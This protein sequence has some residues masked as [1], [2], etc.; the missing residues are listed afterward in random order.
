M[1]FKIYAVVYVLLLLGFLFVLG[2]LAIREYLRE[3]KHFQDTGEALER[4]ETR[5]GVS[6]KFVNVADAIMV[7]VILLF[8]GA[9]VW[10]QRETEVVENAL[11]ATEAFNAK[12]LL[13]NFGGQ[14]LFIGMVVVL[15]FWRTSIVDQFGLL[16]QKYWKKLWWCL[17]VICGCWLTIW[18][19]V[20][21]GFYEY[22]ESLKDGN[23]LQ[24]AVIFLKESDD[25]T[26]IFLL[27]FVAC[28][29]APFSEE[30][31]YRGYIYPV[32]KH[33]GGAVF[34][35]FFSGLLFSLIHF[36]LA[37]GPAL[38]VMGVLLA[39]A[40]EKTRSLWIPVIA[41]CI[42]NSFTVVNI[43]ARFNPEHIPDL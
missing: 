31:L 11:P 22:V 19:T 13:A 18:V 43:A 39:L 1:E 9:G 3:V 16:I 20:Q 32:V 33:Y 40:Y 34:G 5:C 37:G 35:M 38:F 21:S 24:E 41:H 30:V 17:I 27:A 12:I 7:L 15:L 8:T 2:P 28:I 4:K 29:G 42:F 25:F 10:A 23:P 36:N 26:L 6:T 14:M